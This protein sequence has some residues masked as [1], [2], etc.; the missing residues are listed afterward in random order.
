MQLALTVTAPIHPSA[1]IVWRGKSSSMGNAKAAERTAW[2]VQLM[3]KPTASTASMDTPQ[4]MDN[5]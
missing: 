4:W 3:K 1:T 5:A 2:N